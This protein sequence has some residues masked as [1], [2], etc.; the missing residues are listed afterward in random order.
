MI[1]TIEGGGGGEEQV[2]EYYEGVLKNIRRSYGCAVPSIKGE[3]A[4]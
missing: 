2:V 4:I 1:E 3:I